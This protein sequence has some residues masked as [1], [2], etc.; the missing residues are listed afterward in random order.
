MI[1]AKINSAGIVLQFEGLTAQDQLTR[2]ELD[3]LRREL[4]SRD[5]NFARAVLSNGR[6]IQCL[7]YAVPP[8]DALAILKRHGIPGQMLPDENS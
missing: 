2:E 1:T 4:N 7:D 6:I 5:S 3:A 8:Q